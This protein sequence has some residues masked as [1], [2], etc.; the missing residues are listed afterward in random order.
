MNFGLICQ[1]IVSN[2]CIQIRSAP[3]IDL[4]RNLP[5]ANHPGAGLGP[6]A[7]PRRQHFRNDW[8]IRPVILRQDVG[9]CGGRLQDAAIAWWPIKNIQPLC[10]FGIRAIMLQAVS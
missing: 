9:A 5:N 7:H 2:I 6:K 1:L 8:L 10:A 4:A 3:P